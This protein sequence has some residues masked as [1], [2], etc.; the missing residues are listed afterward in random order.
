MQT[1]A[2][3][4]PLNKFP[5]AAVACLRWE[6]LCAVGV[7]GSGIGGGGP[8]SQPASAMY[9]NQVPSKKL[10]R[11]LEAVEAGARWGVGLNSFF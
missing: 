9:M 8:K 4:A 1:H 6:Y 3:H 11:H 10:L 5:E 2:I 7:S